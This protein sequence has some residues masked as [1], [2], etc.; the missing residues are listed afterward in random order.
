MISVLFELEH[1]EFGML[2]PVIP[3]LE[4]FQK[5]CSLENLSRIEAVAI[6]GRPSNNRKCLLP[7]MKIIFTTVH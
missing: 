1:V 5:G 6:N 7:S 3:L 2:I 4:K